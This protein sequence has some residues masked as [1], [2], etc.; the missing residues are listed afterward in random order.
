MNIEERIDAN[1]DA[2]LR[3]SGSR[4]SNYTMHSTLTAMRKAM[5]K[6]MAEEWVR[7]T[8]AGWKASYP[9]P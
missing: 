8:D 9:K 5:R 2:V 3:A 1:L 6:V 7:G 4:L